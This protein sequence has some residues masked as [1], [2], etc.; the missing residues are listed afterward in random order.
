MRAVLQA[1]CA[2]CHAGHLYYGPNFYTREQLFLPAS[3]L[4]I[5][6]SHPIAPG[7]FGEHM[8][9][10]LRDDMMPPAY[11][12][13]AAPTPAERQLVIDWIGA[14]MPAGDC[15]ALVGAP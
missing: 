12:G 10:A 8:A 4:F 3:D 7:T 1:Y 2:N 11:Y 14:G 15:G 9:T 5:V 6:K 13:R